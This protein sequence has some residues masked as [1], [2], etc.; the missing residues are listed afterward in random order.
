MET[1]SALVIVL[2]SSW[3]DASIWV[4]VDVEEC[5]TEAPSRG[6]PILCE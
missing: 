5:M 3:P 1:N 4:V 6:F 2:F